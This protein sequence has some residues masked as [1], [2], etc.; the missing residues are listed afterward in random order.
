MQL[1][2]KQK[3]FSECFSQLLKYSFN[4]EHFQK[5]LTLIADV[6][7]KLRTPKKVVR[8]MSKKSCLRGQF[9]K[10]D[11]KRSQTLLKFKQQHLYILIDHC[12]A[13]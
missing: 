3:Y 1:S 8:S 7:P 13:S 2:L 4:F 6:F 11:G 9:E 5:K 10:E 12:E